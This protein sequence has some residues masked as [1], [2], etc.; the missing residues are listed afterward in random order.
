MTRPGKTAW[1]RHVPAGNRSWR[2]EDWHKNVVAGTVIV[3][4][5]GCLI[6][7]LV[8]LPWAG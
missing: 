4:V 5:A 2:R 3:M 6:P 8:G 1:A 7:N